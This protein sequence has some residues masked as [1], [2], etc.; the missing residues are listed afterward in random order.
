HHGLAPA[1]ATRAARPAGAEID[2]ALAQAGL[3][4]SE[5]NRAA[6]A[7]LRETDRQL[8]QDHE[9]K[10]LLAALDGRFIAPVAGG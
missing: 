4:A 5:P 9:I 7:A 2:A 1:P 6:F 10:G 3:P 8:S